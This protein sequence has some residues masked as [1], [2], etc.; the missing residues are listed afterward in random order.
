MIWYG[1]TNHLTV[2]PVNVGDQLGNN[3]NWEPYC[4]VLGDSAF[5]LGYISYAPDGVANPTTAP[6]DPGQSPQA[7]QQY[8]VTV[9]PTDGSVPRTF[10]G[11]YDDYGH[12]FTNEISYRQNGNPFHVTGDKRYGGTNYMTGGEGS[13]NEWNGSSALAINFFNSDRRYDHP[14]W[15][16]LGLAA[17]TG[18]DSPGAD[19]A[20]RFPVAQMFGI[21]PKNFAQGPVPTSKTLDVTFTSH[22][23]FQ[24][25]DPVAGGQWGRWGGD[26]A[27]LSDGNF[28][29]GI[30][31]RSMVFPN[32]AGNNSILWIVRPDGSWVTNSWMVAPKNFWTGIAAFKG[33]FCVR[34]GS[35][36]Q[37]DWD[38]G[39]YPDVLVPPT[40]N[41][42]LLF[43]YDNLGNCYATNA[44]CASAN[45]VFNNNGRGDGIAITADIRGHYV[46]YT[47]TLAA[48]DT[49][50]PGQSVVA[51]WDGWT[52]QFVTNA[53]WSTSDPTVASHD[54]YGIAVDALDRFCVAN[55]CRFDKNLPLCMYQDVARVG[56]FDGKSIT[57][58]TPEF[59]PFVNHDSDT[60]N[61]MGIE[62]S[63]CPY[64]TM[65]TKQ[66][67]ICAKIWG[68]STNNP[69][70][71]ADTFSWDCYKPSTP[72]CYPTPNTGDSGGNDRTFVYTVFTH[73][74]PVDPPTPR[75]TFKTSGTNATLSYP[76]DNGLFRLQSSTT[77]AAGSFADVIPQ[78]ARVPLP[79]FENPDT[80][81]FTVSLGAGNKYY[82]LVR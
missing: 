14:V 26:L 36:G 3:G 41:D 42:E 69:S 52:G 74:A 37:S 48:S 2:G 21:N 10:S 43:F 60:N 54:R 57:W 49:N 72:Q 67:C 5:L 1:N 46:Y 28:V 13:P 38:S 44:M 53:V 61:L 32:S 63:V 66:I 47:D 39:N 34:V 16:P 45:L 55:A 29:C 15:A 35:F 78:P 51:I 17:T 71:G 31:D 58:L 82:R 68:N 30:E 27:V 62:T 70:A 65:T 79:T 22:P 12:A 56:K 20:V 81:Q 33:G 76:A 40:G 19:Q 50:A 18:G 23:E 59:F 80:F 75:I 77:L 11:F 64:V 24:S 8:Y 4:G 6:N 7:H 25:I 9:V 73:P